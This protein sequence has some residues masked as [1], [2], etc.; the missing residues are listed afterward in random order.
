MLSYRVSSC[1]RLS[2]EC[3]EQK[4]GLGSVKRGEEWPSLRVW[5]ED[6]TPRK[7]IL[8]LN[9]I[10]FEQGRKVAS[11][12]GSVKCHCNIVRREAESLCHSCGHVVNIPWLDSQ[13]FKFSQFCNAL[14]KLRH[15]NI[16]LFMS[17]SK[18]WFAL[19][20]LDQE[21]VLGKSSSN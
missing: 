21:N 6:T 18:K 10:Q 7:N 1:L 14:L 13:Y 17:K 5:I 2:F 9:F 20:R 11:Y 19:K 16:I 8:A 4:F 15:W 3:Q 12:E